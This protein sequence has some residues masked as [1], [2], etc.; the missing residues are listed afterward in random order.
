MVGGLRWGKCI[1][2]VE[3]GVG[4]VDDNCAILAIPFENGTPD[5]N[6]FLLFLFM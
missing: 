1:G 2:G 6:L 3:W 4:V 5:L